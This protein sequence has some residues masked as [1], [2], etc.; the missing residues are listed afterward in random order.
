[1]TRGPSIYLLFVVAG[2]AWAGLL[3]FTRFVAPATLLAFC[4]FFLIFSIALCSTLIPLAYSVD[5][6]VFSKHHYYL[7]TRYALR[8][9]GLLTVATVLNFIF[10]ALHSWNAIMA[11]ITLLTAVILEVLFLAR[12]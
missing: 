1:M 8:Q 10:L 11:L 3:L 12:K 9:S 2:L 5:R 4:I 6:R 7:L